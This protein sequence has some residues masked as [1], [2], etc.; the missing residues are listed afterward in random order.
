MITEKLS[1]FH[2]MDVLL[3]SVHNISAVLT[4]SNPE[5]VSSMIP[6]F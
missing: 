3:K 2:D 1:M 4:G 6:V 5:T